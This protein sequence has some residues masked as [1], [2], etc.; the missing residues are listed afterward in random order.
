MNLYAG[1]IEQNEVHRVLKNVS[2]SRFNPDV[3]IT[4]QSKATKFFISV[5]RSSL[6]ELPLLK[7]DP[8]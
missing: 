7:L 1:S 5:Q 8:T 4:D 2:R 6:V 3:S